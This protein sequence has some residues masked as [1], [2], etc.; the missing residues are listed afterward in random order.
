MPN[1]MALT[2]HKKRCQLTHYLTCTLSIIWS[3]I[4]F[5]TFSFI[6]RILFW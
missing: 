1:E 3:R 6:S 5:T 4:Y 2:K